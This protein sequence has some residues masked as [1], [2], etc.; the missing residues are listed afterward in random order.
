M[1]PGRVGLLL[2]L[3]AAAAGAAVEGTAAGVKWIAPAS[4]KLQA[5]RQMRVVTYDIP[6]APGSEPGECGVFYFGEGQ[7]GDVEENFARWVKQFEGATPAKKAERTVHGLRVHT[8]DVSGTYLASGG[9]MMH[10]QGKKQAG[11]RLLGAIVEAPQGLVFF[12]CTGPT[13]TI[14]KAQAEF[15]AF[16]ASLAKAPAARL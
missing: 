12:K 2:L 10:S 3:V 13:A 4:W 6:A 14:G 8:I 16:L 9:P 15:D 7:G 11:F 5:A 1:R